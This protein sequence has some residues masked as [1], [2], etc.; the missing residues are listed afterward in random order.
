MH[1][2]CPLINLLSVTYF[3]FIFI[4]STGLWMCT[5]IGNLCMFNV[6]STESMCQNLVHI[7]Y[8]EVLK[9]QISLGLEH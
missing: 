4:P 2:V 7:N 6:N 3:T 9:K 8:T 5:Q 1:N